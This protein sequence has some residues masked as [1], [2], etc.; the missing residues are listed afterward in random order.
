MEKFEKVDLRQ[1]NTFGISAIA[2]EMYDCYD[3]EEVHEALKRTHGKRR[4]VIGGGSN[5]LLLSDFKGAIIRPLIG[6]VEVRLAD[7]DH[8]Y[9]SVG[10]GVEW[11]DFVRWTIENG[12]YGVENLSGIPG[13][14]GASP[15]QN[16]G[17]YGVE[18]KDTIMSVEG[19][20]ADEPGMFD[21][22]AKECR[23][24]Y[25]DS[26]F[27]HEMRGRGVITHV[28]FRLNNKPGFKLGYGAIR[29]QMEADGAE[30]TAANIRAAI[31]KIRD[32]KLPDPKVQ[33]N[34]GSFFKNPE[35]DR[36]KADAI[37]AEHPDMPHFDTPSGKVKI[38]AGWLI[39]KSGMKGKSLGPAAVHDRQ[40][41]VIVNKGGATGRDIMAMCEAVK[42]RVKEA[43]GIELTAE[44]NMV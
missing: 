44:V 6:G 22:S 27:K 37:R 34:A 30:L 16:I 20:W 10:A 42:S 31:K 28:T 23:F 3:E 4:Y 40:A 1:Y 25:R 12:L 29:Q 5:I 32:S 18:A 24:G 36:A 21:L 14:V 8:T 38:P 35:V 11:D 26:I 13:H 39:E 19:V 7:S 41:L 33:G 17:A 2:D 9:V 15:V 43:F